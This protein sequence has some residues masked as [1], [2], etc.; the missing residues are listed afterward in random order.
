MHIFF[1]YLYYMNSSDINF[2][3]CS[4]AFLLFLLYMMCPTGFY[5]GSNL[6]EELKLHKKLETDIS[7]MKS[8]LEEI[9][10]EIN[11][12]KNTLD[13]YKNDVF[14]SSTRTKML[15]TQ[16]ILK[17][18]IT[19]KEKT[20]N[21][22]DNALKKYDKILGGKKK[23]P[24]DKIEADRQKRLKKLENQPAVDPKLLIKSQNITKKV[25]NVMGESIPA[26]KDPKPAVVKHIPPSVKSNVDNKKN[27]NRGEINQDSSS[28]DSSS[29][30]SSSSDNYVELVSTSDDLDSE[31]AN[32]IAQDIEREQFND[33]MNAFIEANS[34]NI[35]A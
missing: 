3:I 31:A 33:S 12:N 23:D 7:T 30:D 1:I 13:K 27:S 11:L 32:N 10:S 8:R 25:G 4:I 2:N 20:I 17:N 19:E 34:N 29:E 22:L 5:G 35:D 24:L 9:K 15:E 26:I 28:E 6:D 18:L 14:N 16:I 21:L